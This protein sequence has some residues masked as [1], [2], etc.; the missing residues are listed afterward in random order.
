MREAIEKYRNTGFEVGRCI[1]G[2]VLRAVREEACGCRAL[3]M[4][5]RWCTGW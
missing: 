2:R 5:G 4:F 3:G 1:K